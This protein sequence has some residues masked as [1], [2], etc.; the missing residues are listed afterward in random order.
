MHIYI[1]IYILV[2]YIIDVRIPLSFEPRV[3]DPA[4]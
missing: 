1:Y 3:P 4:G 2:Y